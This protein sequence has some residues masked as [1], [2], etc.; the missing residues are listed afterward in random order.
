MN[1]MPNCTRLFGAFC[2]VTLAAGA[3][4]DVTADDLSVTGNIHLPG[5]SLLQGGALEIPG[6]LRFQR[7]GVSDPLPPY[8]GNVR[9]QPGGNFEIQPLGDYY[10]SALDIYP[11]L[12]MKPQTDALAELTIHRIA[13]SNL[14]HEM[15]SI[16]ALADS[17]QRFGVIVEAHGA[18][19]IKP[20]DFHMI[21][22]GLLDVDREIPPYD[23]IAMRVKTDGT[24]QFGVTRNGGPPGPVDAISVERDHPGAAGIYPSDSIR[25]TAKQMGEG[26]AVF[27]WRT[28]VQIDASTG[29]LYVL[30]SRESGA[31]YE[32]KLEV[33]SAGDVVIASAGAGVILTSP[34]GNRWRLTVTD[35]G[36]LAASPAEQ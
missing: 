30:E 27:D 2:V 21:Q 16:S 5:L 6:Q 19:R 17:Q 23:A 26:S 24:V 4:R 7:G 11:T 15:L 36:K 34:N 33:T 29:S 1:R 25:L 20:L 3:Q 18:G 32:R 10:R 13:P 35:D 8:Q 9:A 31:P 22:G 28:N 14:G 12:G